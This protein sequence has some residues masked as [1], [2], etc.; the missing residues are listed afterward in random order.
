[1]I[2]LERKSLTRLSK[3]GNKILRP[4]KFQKI[5]QYRDIFQIY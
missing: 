2:D 3:Q 5:I 4:N 1:M